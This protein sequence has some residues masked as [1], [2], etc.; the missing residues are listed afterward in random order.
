MS[1][2]GSLYDEIGVDYA[3]TRRPDRRIAEQ[4]SRA[5]G[6]ARSLV[7][8]GAGAGSYEPRDRRVVAVE[9][10]ATM[11]SQRPQGAGPALR[12]SAEALPLADDAVDAALA[13]LTLHHW[14][15]QRRGFAEMRRVARHRIVILT[16]DQQVWESFWLVRDYFPRIADIDRPRTLPIEEL[17]AALGG[18]EV[19]P[20]PVPHDCVD[21]FC[22]AFWRRPAAYLDPR[23][24]AGISVCSLIPQRELDDGLRRLASD[25]R[26]GA[27]E[28]R[29]R[30][31]LALDALDIGYRLVVADASSER[32]GGIDSA[33]EA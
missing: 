11:I 33:G 6:D 5:L 21:G 23:V 9:P 32:L 26:D 20:V 28:A 17:A 4:I 10:S 24:R 29:Y 8:V 16:W 27:W 2:V 30:E 18:G 7:N 13:T 19:L 31:L 14:S 3:Q 15:D 22:G 1:S 25:L 12:A